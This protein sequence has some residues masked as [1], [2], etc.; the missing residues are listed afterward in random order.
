M[1]AHP[2]KMMTTVAGLDP[3]PKPGSVLLTITASHVDADGPVAS[4]VTAR[5]G[6][7]LAEILEADYVAVERYVLQPRSGRSQ[8]K[9]AQT[10]TMVMAEDMYARALASVG[11]ASLQ[12]LGPGNVKPWATD[13]RLERYGVLVKGGHHRDACRHA[14]YYAVRLR[15]LPRL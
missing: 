9:G 15:L 8:D 10:A 14:L 4:T 6:V 11:R 12:Y 13:R 1:T 2:A 5:T 7:E 3:G